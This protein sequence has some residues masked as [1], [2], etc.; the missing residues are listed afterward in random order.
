MALGSPQQVTQVT[1]NIVIEHIS[2]QDLV[3]EFL[4][5]EVFPTLNG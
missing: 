4:A 3:Q 2:T 5:N 1:F